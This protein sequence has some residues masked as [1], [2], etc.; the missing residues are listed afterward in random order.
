LNQLKK[1]LHIL[2]A[3]FA[4]LQLA[5]GPYALVQIYAWGTMITTYSKDTGI[6]QGAKD[7]FGGEKPC[8]LC[9]K[10]TAAKKA[11]GEKNQQSPAPAPSVKI[12]Q[13]FVASSGP[14]LAPPA[15]EDM[16]T[17]LYYGHLLEN[18]T[19]ASLPLVPPPKVVA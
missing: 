2:F 17:V 6:I 4:C 9:C 18:R 7:T 12:S 3:L 16:P 5:F 15:S 11:D 10:I 8:R 19:S 14:V 13:E 1:S